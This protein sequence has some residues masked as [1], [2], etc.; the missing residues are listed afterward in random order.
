MV[1]DA[2]FCEL[3]KGSRYL[4]ALRAHSVLSVVNPSCPTLRSQ[5]S[6][7]S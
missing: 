1:F 4:R 2:S 7:R 3:P 6:E 5:Q